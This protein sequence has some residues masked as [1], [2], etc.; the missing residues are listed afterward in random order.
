[1]CSWVNVC[2]TST[3][4][5][6]CC[7]NFTS[8]STLSS[9]R[10]SLTAII[11]PSDCSSAV[12]TCPM[13][14]TPI[15]SPLTQQRLDTGTLSL[16]LASLLPL[17]SNSAAPSPELKEVWEFRT[18]TEVI[19]PSGHFSTATSLGEAQSGWG[20]SGSSSQSDPSGTS[21]A[22][23]IGLLCCPVSSQTTRAT[24]SWGKPCQLTTPERPST[25]IRFPT[26]DEA[27]AS[28]KDDGSG[29]GGWTLTSRLRSVSSRDRSRADRGRRGPAGRGGGSGGLASIRG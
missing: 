17:L 13:L 20:S 12:Y 21:L 10:I 7:R 15:V 2:N 29:A 16:W 6:S 9:I 25:T 19:R 3:S 18:D 8:A 22:I 14:P 5:A 27:I 28:V 4:F 26:R 1:M 23:S 24:A 11:L